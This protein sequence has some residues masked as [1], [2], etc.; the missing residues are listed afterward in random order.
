MILGWVDMMVCDFI[1][2]SRIDVME[3]SQDE[4]LL[5]E[6]WMLGYR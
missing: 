2:K 1:R 5:A 4:Q 3:S 6:I